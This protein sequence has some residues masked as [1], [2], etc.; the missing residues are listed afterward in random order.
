MLPGQP[1]YTAPPVS[2][3]G[4]AQ[5]T[6]PAIV[7]A[8]PAQLPQATEI[9]V[10]RG[11][12]GRAEPAAHRGSGAGSGA[13]RLAE[14][15]HRWSGDGP[16]VA[17]AKYNPRTGEYMGSDGKLYRQADLATAPT[18]WRDLMPM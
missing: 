10:P 1:L 12:A 3:P 13:R 2:S 17:V 5:V 6:D 16:S 15:L 18:S 4:P 11:F 7:P 14:R 9:P 8:P